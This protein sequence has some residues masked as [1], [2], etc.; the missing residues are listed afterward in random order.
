VFRAQRRAAQTG[1]FIP[2]N[3]GT[4]SA[5]YGGNQVDVLLHG[6]LGGGTFNL[7][8][9]IELGSADKVEAARLLPGG[10]ALSCLFIKSVQPQHRVV[11]RALGK[12]VHVFLSLSKSIL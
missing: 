4:V 8:S 3:A 11:V 10:I 7:A 5:P 12:A 1:L 2:L 6:I 9:G